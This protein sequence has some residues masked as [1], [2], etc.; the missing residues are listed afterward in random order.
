MDM[1]SFT[2]KKTSLLLIG[3]MVLSGCNVQY[4]LLYYPSAAAPS[5]EVLSANNLKFWPASETGYRGLAGTKEMRDAK[6][7][8]VVFHGNGGTAADRT[9]YVRA[10]GGL[11]YRVILAEYP[12]YGGRKG[13][14]GEKS[15]VNDSVETVRIASEKYG[16]PILLLGESLGCGVAAAVAADSAVKIDGIVLM[17][18]WDTLLSVARSHFRFFPVKWLLKDRYDSVGNLKSFEGRIVV[19]GAERDRVIPIRHARALYDSLPDTRKRMWTIQ[20]AGHNDWPAVMD[21]QLWKEIMDFV[22][23]SKVGQVDS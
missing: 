8:V 13:A 14:L 22:S 16:G 2:F 1:I 20:G 3:A 11:G 4:H 19:V 10:L 23:S 5:E 21:A 9:F 15:F 12:A 7:T 6:G 18:P 17:T